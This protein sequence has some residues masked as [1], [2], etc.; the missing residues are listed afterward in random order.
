MGLNNITFKS[1]IHSVF[2]SGFV[3]NHTNIDNVKNQKYLIE[4]YNQ[5]IANKPNEEALNILYNDETLRKN[6]LK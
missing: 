5:Y 4:K 1:D 6:L 2:L 3:K